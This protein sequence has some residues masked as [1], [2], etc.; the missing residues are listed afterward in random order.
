MSFDPSADSAFT[1]QLDDIDVAIQKYRA[2]QSKAVHH[3]LTSRSN[4]GN[5]NNNRMNRGSNNRASARSQNYNNNNKFNRPY[6]NQ[7]QHFQH[8]GQ[9]QQ[10]SS[11]HLHQQQLP[12]LNIPQM[13]YFQSVDPSSRLSSPIPRAMLS[14]PDNLMSSSTG[15][16]SSAD[17]AGST[18]STNLNG[19]V[20]STFF[21]NNASSTTLPPPVAVSNHA[22]GFRTTS[23]SFDSDFTSFESQIAKQPV[24]I[25]NI[26]TN[27]GAV[28][29]SNT[30]DN[31]NNGLVSN[32]IPSSSGITDIN[33]PVPGMP[34]SNT[35][36]GNNNV[37]F[38]LFN[39][40]IWGND[41]SVWG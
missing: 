22:F 33:N 12:R 21:N 16:I 30:F 8:Q 10:S 23:P 14:S 7:I 32:P 41:M 38:G 28:S 9:V 4:S 27:N 31:F 18:F 25:D 15:S 17:S 37:N 2:L 11:P 29:S 5:Y 19:S 39:K 36:S 24:G 6:V 20:G 1:S 3:Q 35:F 40:S 26:F 34:G 13:N